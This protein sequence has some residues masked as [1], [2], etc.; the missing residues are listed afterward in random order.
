MQTNTTYLAVQDLQHSLDRFMKEKLK[1]CGYNV[2][3][4]IWLVA[5]HLRLCCLL[6]CWQENTIS[7]AQ[8]DLIGKS[9]E[10]WCTHITSNILIGIANSE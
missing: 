9:R 8:D 6:R 3:V 5:Y 10:L 2:A 1:A 4:V 7:T